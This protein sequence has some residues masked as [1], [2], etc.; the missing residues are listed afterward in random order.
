MPADKRAEKRDDVRHADKHRNQHDIRHAGDEHKNR[1]N[2]ADDERIDD[3][4][5]QKAAENLVAVARGI[6]DHIRR[7]RLAERKEQLFR[8]SA[9][10]ILV[11]EDIDRD[12][13][14]DEEIDQKADDADE[15][16]RS[17][18]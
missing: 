3:F 18:K 2:D 14:A 17:D 16:C 15:R 6:D 4:A 8:L 13:D 1:V 5:G 9:E 7:F 12:D 10:L 11:A